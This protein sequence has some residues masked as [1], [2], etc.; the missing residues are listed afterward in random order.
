[1]RVMV[2]CCVVSAHGGCVLFFSNHNIRKI[3]MDDS[4]SSA[5]EGSPFY[6][7]MFLA[8]HGAVFVDV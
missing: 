1:M 6:C 2:L 3:E 8:V 4:V 5:V 7:V